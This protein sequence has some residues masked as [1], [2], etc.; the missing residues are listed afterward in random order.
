MT[1][2]LKELINILRK[3]TPE[4]LGKAWKERYKMYHTSPTK[5]FDDFIHS[6]RSIYADLDGGVDLI[7][8]GGQV[9]FVR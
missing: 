6:D 7:K 4:E 8:K 2:D 1:A 5:E 9:T 3:G